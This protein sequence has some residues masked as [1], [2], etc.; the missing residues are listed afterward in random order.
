MKKEIFWGIIPD[1]N[2]QPQI[3]FG[4]DI[5][6]GKAYLSVNG[7]DIT[8]NL[9]DGTGVCGIQQVADGVADGFDFTGKNPNATKA[10]PTLTGVIPYGATGNFASAFGGKSRA[11]GKRSFANGTT[12]IAYGDYSHAEGDKSV[13]Y[14]ATSHAEGHATF[15]QGPHSHT[16]GNQ[17]IA[18]AD[19]AHAEGNQTVAT[20]AHSHAEGEFS[21]ANA[22]G[23]H[24][25]GYQTET[26]GSYSHSAG[27][28]TKAISGAAHAE[29]IETIAGVEGSV[30]VNGTG[31]GAH[32]EGGKTVASADCAHAEGYGTI[33]SGIY[34]HA[35][36]FGTTANGIYSH[37]SGKGTVAGYECQTVIGKNNKNKSN[38]LFEVGNGTG[39]NSPSNAFEV[40]NSGDL[41]ICKDGKIYSLHKMLAAYFTDTN[42]M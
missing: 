35:E 23:S 11:K 42:L 28:K 20:K 12:T 41:G 38:T 1:D 29:G 16:E 17:T 3:E 30:G 14:G 25:E 22:Y 24:A 36:G 18:S 15:A 7:D 37:A 34:S 2:E 40:Y 10:D 39:E 13:S 26:L 8:V 31:A 27:Y 19:C 5:Q 21:Q 32:A 4:R 9:Q 6:T 33:A